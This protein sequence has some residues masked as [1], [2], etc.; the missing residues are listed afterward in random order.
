MIPAAPGAR[1]AATGRIS[2]DII[3]CNREFCNQ[4]RSIE[5]NVTD[6]EFWYIGIFSE[7]AVP[8]TFAF[9]FNSTCIPD[10]QTDN[11]G[12][13]SPD[14]SG[15]CICEIDYEGINCGKSKGLGPQYIVLI[16]IASLVVAS[17][18][19]GFVAWAYMRRKRADYEIVS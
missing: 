9:W 16:I 13:C 1:F 2:A 17:A 6:V 3:N 4:V 15:R 18:I 19:I 5:Y 7:A 8:V 14:G 12:Q 11:H 10:C